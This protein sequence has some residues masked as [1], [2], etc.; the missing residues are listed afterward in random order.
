LT[1]IR[2]KDEELINDM[3]AEIG[4]DYDGDIIV[5]KDLIELGI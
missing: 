1:H 4:E 2:E 5:G 3:V